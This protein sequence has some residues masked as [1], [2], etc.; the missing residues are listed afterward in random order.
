MARMSVHRVLQQALGVP[1]MLDWI[2]DGLSL[3]DETDSGTLSGL[4]HVLYLSGCQD[5]ADGRVCDGVLKRWLGRRHGGGRERSAVL[6]RWD[7]SD[8]VTFACV[9][10]RLLSYGGST[11]AWVGLQSMT[12]LVAHVVR[13]S[14]V[15]ARRRWSNIQLDSR[16]FR[17]LTD[18]VLEAATT[19]EELCAAELTRATTFLL[20]ETLSCMVPHPRA[21]ALMALAPLL[22]VANPVV[23]TIVNRTGALI[24]RAQ[25]A[26]DPRA[27]VHWHI[28][29]ASTSLTLLEA[30]VQSHNAEHLPWVDRIYP[31]RDVI[32]F[33]IAS[34]RDSKYRVLEPMLRAAAGGNACARRMLDSFDAD[35]DLGAVLAMACLSLIART[36][37]VNRA[38]NTGWAVLANAIAH[39]CRLGCN[40][41]AFPIGGLVEEVL[42][43]D[44]RLLPAVEAALRSNGVQTLFRWMAHLAGNGEGRQR[45]IQ[46][47][48][49]NQ[50]M[51][52]AVSHADPASPNLALLLRHVPIA[53]IP[54]AASYLLNYTVGERNAF[55]R[56]VVSEVYRT[57][58]QPGSFVLPQAIAMAQAIGHDAA[59]LLPEGLRDR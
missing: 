11:P 24:R 39:P 37:I 42:E 35:G 29:P 19:G 49:I 51:W 57:R 21:Y 4:L 6:E 25:A 54:R 22:A 56:G 38:I 13:A 55:W 15:R 52:K 43:A 30:L 48:R 8:S 14:M 31:I 10:E 40:M 53:A 58:I 2:L 20:A 32:K 27:R 47:Q 59:E 36:R 23:W 3:A 7:P 12:L 9:S 1:Q 34:D 28:P 5:A 46:L 18:A 26:A 33:Y 17:R 16:I 45:G 44:I 41:G 50:I